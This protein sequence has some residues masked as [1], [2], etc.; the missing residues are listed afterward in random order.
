[1]DYKQIVPQLPKTTFPD[2]EEESRGSAP[3]KGDT[4]NSAEK[5]K[6]GKRRYYYD[7]AY[8]YQ[9]YVPEEDDG[10]D[11]DGEQEGAD[12]PLR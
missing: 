12:K 1:M 9:D 11:A 6:G 3:G 4:V 8:G 5:E 2:D 10:S 7:D